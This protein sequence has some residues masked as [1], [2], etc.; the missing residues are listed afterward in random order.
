MLST[1]SPRKPGR[2]QQSLSLLPYHLLWHRC[3]WPV[4][5]TSLDCSGSSKQLGKPPA[6]MRL[7]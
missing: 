7:P 2:P 1:Q 3:L 5:P 6:L 4:H